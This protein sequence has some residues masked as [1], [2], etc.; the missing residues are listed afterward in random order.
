MMNTF[1]MKQKYYQDEHFDDAYHYQKEAIQK[2]A[3]NRMVLPEMKKFILENL[4]KRRDFKLIVDIAYRL[5]IPKGTNWIIEANRVMEKHGYKIFME[6]KSSDTQW[7]GHN[8]HTDDYYY[9]LKQL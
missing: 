7:R 9:I 4:H 6:L 8:K 5:K 2:N 1:V 3:D